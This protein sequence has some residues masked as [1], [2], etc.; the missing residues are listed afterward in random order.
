MRKHYIPFLLLIFFSSCFYSTRVQY[1]GNTYT[2]TGKLDV[3]VADTS[4]TK[5][6]TVMG[7]GY[8]KAGSGGTNWNK[9][10]KD[11]IREGKIH[12]AD[13][14]L[15]VQRSAVSPL[16][17]LSSRSTTDS[18]GKTIVTTSNSST[19][20]PVSWWHDILFLKYQ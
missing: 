18:I 7:R 12:G 17:A 3:Y 2:A 1:V 11:A 5:P 9:V 4:I 14:V 10:Q 15:I 20:F 13:A 19:Y 8:I 6:Y 16:P